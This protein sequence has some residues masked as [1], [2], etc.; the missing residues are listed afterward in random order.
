ML[1]ITEV[2]NLK[3]LLSEIEL[4]L[5]LLKYS[6]K[7]VIFNLHIFSWNLEYSS[8]ARVKLLCTFYV[9]KNNP[10][11]FKHCTNTSFLET[12]ALLLLFSNKT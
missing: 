4:F 2:T 7:L 12:I 9:N 1:I 3:F 6:Y 5:A 11:V 8:I 10:C